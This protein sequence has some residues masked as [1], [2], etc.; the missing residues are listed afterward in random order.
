[1]TPELLE[2]MTKLAEFLYHADGKDVKT[3]T[4]TDGRISME[5]DGKTLFLPLEIA[6]QLSVTAKILAQFDPNLKS[7]ATELDR[8][9]SE[10]TN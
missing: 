3:D 6:K 7:M 1:M 9:C 2:A 10:L 4:T 8:L 5:C